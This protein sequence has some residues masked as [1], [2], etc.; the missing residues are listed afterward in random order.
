MKSRHGFTLI[1]LLVVIAIIGILAAILLPALARAREAAQRASCQN[2]LKQI[3]LS[4]KMYAD[5][6]QGEWPWPQ[7]SIE[8]IWN[9]DADP[10]VQTGDTTTG[11]WMNPN[12]G[13]MF[14][15]YLNDLSLLVCPSSVTVNQADIVHPQ[16]GAMEL[17]RVCED[18][19]SPGSRDNFRGM[20]LADENYTYVSVVL[21][22]MSQDEPQILVSELIGGA[23]P[24]FTGPAQFIVALKYLI[25]AAFDGQFGGDI[26]LSQPVPIDGSDYRGLG[27]GNAR[28]DTIFRLREGVER[29]LITDI[30]NPGAATT[31]Q[32]DLFVMWDR[33][34]TATEEFNHVPG[35]SNVLYM[36]GHVEFIRYPGEAPVAPGVARAYA[37]L[38]I[39]K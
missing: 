17:H 6:N 37:P 12:L 39:H 15:D 14:P 30:N 13:Q 24:S 33:L 23:N 4:F 19:A 22:Q 27:Y 28:S 1:E 38:A 29:F 25:F 21:D 18:P 36:D 10:V 7:T 26:D 9:C 31:A 11:H 34:S 35:G 8:P 32:S 3:A 16:T 2:N 5:E 20:S